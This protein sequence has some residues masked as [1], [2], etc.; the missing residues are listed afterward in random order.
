MTLGIV[1]QLARI[2]VDHFGVSRVTV[3]TSKS[4]K[5]MNRGLRKIGFVYEGIC[6]HGYGDKDAVVFGLFG[7]RL[8]TLSGRMMQ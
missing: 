6:H 7:K 5:I 2:A 4:N 3:K 8:A 1:K